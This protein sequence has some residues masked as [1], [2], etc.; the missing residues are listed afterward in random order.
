MENRRPR[1][2]VR[3]SPRR[4]LTAAL[5][6]A[7]VA[8]VPA[9]SAEST[10]ADAA[11]DKVLAALPKAVPEALA[12]FYGQRPAWRTCEGVGKEEFECARLKAPLDY[13][14]PTVG[15]LDLALSRKK[16][17]GPGSRLGSLLVN[18]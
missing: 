14:N 9:C 18:P 6:A 10:T 8:L 12:P 7:A 15:T 16:A 11:G 3:R 2:P 17:T 13:D 5:L 1:P 4:P